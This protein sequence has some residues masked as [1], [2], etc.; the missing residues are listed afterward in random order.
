MLCPKK[1]RHSLL[2][3]FEK[4]DFGYMRSCNLDHSFPNF[5]VHRPLLASKN[6]HRSIHPCSPNCRMSSWQ[7]IYISELII[8]TLCLQCTFFMPA[9]KKYFILNCHYLCIHWIL[10]HRLLVWRMVLFICLTRS[11]KFGSECR[12]LNPHVECDIYSVTIFRFCCC[13]PW[14]SAS[15]IICGK[16]KQF[17]HYTYGE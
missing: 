8:H 6:N 3:K 16:Q 17:E 4:Y 12:Q 5:F 14:N 2:C 13:K 7:V 1:W 10:L 15:Q 11:F 9:Q